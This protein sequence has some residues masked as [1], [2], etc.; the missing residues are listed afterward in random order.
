LVPALFRLPSL[1]SKPPT[2]DTDFRPSTQGAALPRQRR[3]V[4][5][6]LNS[7]ASHVV[8]KQRRLVEHLLQNI[9]R[10]MAIDLACFHDEIDLSRHGYV[11]ERVSRHGDDVSLLVRREHAQIVSL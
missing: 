7:A 10:A 4:A 2:T 3:N 5:E 6:D 1:L 8:P 11:G 9:N